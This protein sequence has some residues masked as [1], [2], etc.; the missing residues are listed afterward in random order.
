[1][2]DNRFL[3]FSATQ[4]V[5]VLPTLGNEY[6]GS[7]HLYFCNPQIEIICPEEVREVNLLFFFLR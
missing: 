4:F 6:S 7:R 5:V 3:L 1:M 2:G